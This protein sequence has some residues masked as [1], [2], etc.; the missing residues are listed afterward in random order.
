MKNILFLCLLLG[1][2]GC[3]KLSERYKQQ[4]PTNVFY[5]LDDSKDTLNSMDMHVLAKY[6]FD[7]AEAADRNGYEDLYRLIKFNDRDTA[8]NN[9]IIHDFG[10]SGG[11]RVTIIVDGRKSV[12]VY[13]EEYP[14]FSGEFEGYYMDKGGN[15]TPIFV[16]QVGPRYGDF[17]IEGEYV[18]CDRIYLPTYFSVRGKIADTTFVM[19]SILNVDGSP[20]NRHLYDSLATVYYPEMPHPKS[21]KIIGVDN[22]YKVFVAQYPEFGLVMDTSMCIF[23]NDTIDLSDIDTIRYKR[24]V[25]KREIAEA[26]LAQV[27]PKLKNGVWRD[28]LFLH[29]FIHPK[30][31]NCALVAYYGSLKERTIIA[32]ATK[33]YTIY[34][35]IKGVLYGYYTDTNGLPLPAIANDTYDYD[36]DHSRFPDNMGDDAT[37][38]YRWRNG[39]L[40]ADSILSVDWAPATPIQTKLWYELCLKDNVFEQIKK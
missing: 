2:I 30:Y 39:E 37:V 11:G 23:Y 6:G 1:C 20:L 8:Y 15:K 17:H 4:A 16:A 10:G 33:P 5:N 28:K 3:H 12:M 36:P 18:W 29:Y 35:N 7:D 32:S 27:E 22:F 19:D 34:N 24:Y 40:V 14:L 26:I 21:T 9:F 38:L 31:G 25:Q 13:G